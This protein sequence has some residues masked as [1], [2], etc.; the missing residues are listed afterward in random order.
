MVT[1]DMQKVEGRKDE[2]DSLCLKYLTEL[3][4]E[5]AVAIPDGNAER[6]SVGAKKKLD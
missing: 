2:V 1:E 3:Y 4:G 5:S 6:R